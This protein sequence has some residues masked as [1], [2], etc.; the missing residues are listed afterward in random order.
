MICV[1]C[2][3]PT[4]RAAAAVAGDGRG[5]I[6]SRCYERETGCTRPLPESLQQA[7]R[8]ALDVLAA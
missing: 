7:L 2:R 8:P 5:C 6:C 1:I 4:C 3:E